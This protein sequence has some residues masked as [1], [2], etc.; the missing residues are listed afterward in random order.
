[1]SSIDFF[2]VLNDHIPLFLLSTVIAIVVYIVICKQTFLSILDPFTLPLIGSIFGCAVVIFLYLSQNISASNFYSYIFTQIAFWGGFILAQNSKLLSFRT[3]LKI[4]IKNEQDFAK[5][6]FITCIIFDICCQLLFY[7]ILGIPALMTSR[8]DATSEGGGAGILLRIIN[9]C[10]PI[11]IFISASYLFNKNISHTQRKQ[12]FIYIVYLCIV[13][14]LNGA[15]SGIL[16]ITT[17]LFN[18]IYLYRNTVKT[19]YTKLKTNEVKYASILMLF[20]IAVICIQI[21]N[22]GFFVAFSEL[23]NRFVSFGDTYWMAYPN[24]SWQSID[25]THP[26]YAIF[27]GILGSLR[28]LPW[29]SL[30]N[31]IGLDLFRLYYD[32]DTLM[33]PNARH[34]VFGLIYFGQV[35]SIIF[36][37]IIGIGAGKLRKLFKTFDGSSIIT[38]IFISLFYTSSCSIETDITMFTSDIAS[39]ILVIPLIFGFSFMLYCLHHTTKC[40]HSY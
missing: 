16:I 9:V 5:H 11:A 1:M 15:K 2:L 25:N 3:H 17:A 32:L 12:C 14:L 10:R 38:A 21:G 40:S 37:L 8:L 29:S 27:A 24:D 23:I 4:K 33:G 6:I 28:I 26:F 31:P 35:G 18:Y 19:L 36:S 7:I 30:P 20:P 22:S 34:N 39:Y 13:L